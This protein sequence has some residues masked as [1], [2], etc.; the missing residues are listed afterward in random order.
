MKTINKDP[1]GCKNLLF[2]IEMAVNN[3]KFFEVERIP[4]ITTGVGVTQAHWTADLSSI[5]DTAEIQA[6]PSQF[7]K[8]AREN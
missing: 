8:S 5:L 2:D 1:E 6:R 7:L 4:A 3:I